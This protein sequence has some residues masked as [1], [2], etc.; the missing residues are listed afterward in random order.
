MNE[1]DVAL[2]CKAL[3]DSNR[4][5]ILE[6]ITDNEKYACN[7]LDNLDISQSTLSYHM[8]ILSE[9]GLVKT[10]RD[11]KWSHYSLDEEVY[12]EFTEYLSKFV[13]DK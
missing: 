1:V 12:K 11:G 13:G 7:I 4:V 8:K 2:I 6:M 9:S 5:K 10:R 3:A